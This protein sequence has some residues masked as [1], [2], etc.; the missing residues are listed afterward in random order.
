[1]AF[2]TANL[3]QNMLSG[4]RTTE[5]TNKTVNSLAIPLMGSPRMRAF[6]MASSEW[7]I[8][9][10]NA[11]FCTQ[12]GSIVI[13]KYTPPRNL[14]IPLNSQFT[15]SP[16]FKTMMKLADMIPRP[17]NE[18][19]VSIR[20]AAADKKLALLMSKPKKRTPNNRYINIL[21]EVNRKLQREPEINMVESPVG[22]RSIVSSVPI[23]CSLL[24][25]PVK[26]DIAVCRYP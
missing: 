25:A 4:S 8:G 21:N 11:N 18:V 1:M 19:M 2:F 12:R 16:L 6:L 9:R 20:Q 3:K 22:E 10:K 5:N 23:Y 14:D 7:V 24:M 15:G 17:L 26:L 13:G